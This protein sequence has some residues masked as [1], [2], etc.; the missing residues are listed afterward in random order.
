MLAC[1][2][3]NN[4]WYHVAVTADTTSGLLRLFVNGGEQDVDDISRLTTKIKLQKQVVGREHDGTQYARHFCGAIDDVR[5]Y[6]RA[7]DAAEVQALCPGAVPLAGRDTRNIR[8]GSIIPDE[9]Y[10]DQPYVVINRDGSWMCTL[11]T[12]TG[13]EGT[14]DS[15]VI[16]TIS[17]DQGRTWSKPVE[18]EPADGP[19][20]VYSLPLVTPAGRIYVFYNYNGENFRCKGRSDCVGWMVY[21]YSD[22]GGRTWS[23]DRYRLPMRMTAVDRTNSFGGEVQIFWGIGKPITVGS[24]AVFAF[25]KCG[26]HVI[27]RSEG[28]FFRSDNILAEPDPEKIEWLLLPEGEVGLKHPDY[29]DVQA[30]QN[31]VALSD[32]SIYCM[33]RTTN[34]YPCHAYS[35]DLARTWTVPEYATY[36]PGGRKMKN[37]RACPK[38]WRCTNGKFLFWFHNHSGKSFK[39]RNPAWVAG[40]VERDGR[41]YWSQPEILLYDPDPNATMS[42]PDLIEQ[43]GRYWVTETN[44]TI[45]RVHE[46]D[47]ALLEGLWH[48]GLDKTVAQ[49]GLVIE[50]A[51]EQLRAGSLDLPGPLDLQATGGVSLDVW[52][53]L[54]ELDEGQTIV[55]GRR[56]DAG[57]GL[58]LSITE[59]GTVR[60]DLSD[61]RGSASWDCDPGLIEAGKLHHVVAIVDAGPRVISFVVDG[62]LCDGGDARQYGW[63]HYPGDLGDVAG[64]GTLRVGPAVKSLRVYGRYLRTSEAVANYHAGP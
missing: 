16:T 42:Y 15:H 19:E 54:D 63:T 39:G 22:D 35:R 5:I 41:I 58:A 43:D 52:L 64:S 37:P 29:G 34:G 25:S 24:S 49:E 23:K 6:G 57:G 9:G 14:A 61:G 20:A 4:T 17:A 51:A 21:R 13:H 27:N 33:Y 31:I 50:A 60:L 55:D 59:S 38:V 10:C 45:A 36:T 62:Q 32:G 12:S 11:T 40:G 56:P 48:Q 26:Q 30:E 46:I 44:K 18:L 7:L 3:E 53:K 47:A 2:Y 8:T 28:W 1:H